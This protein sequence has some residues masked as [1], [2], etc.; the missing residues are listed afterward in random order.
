MIARALSTEPKLVL[1]D[2]PTGSL[3]TQPRRARCWSCCASSAASARLAV[4]LVTHDPQAAAFADRVHTL[5][6]GQLVGVRARPAVGRGRRA[7]DEVRLSSILLLYRARLRARVVLVQELFAVARHRRGRGA[8][9][10]LAGRQHEPQR[11][12]GAS[13]RGGI[14]GDMRLPA[15]GARPGRLRRDGCW[16]R[17]SASPGVQRGG[18]GARGARQRDRP[19]AASS[20]WI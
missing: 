7:A 8:A 1:A 17:C 10:R 18:A 14:V 20:R 4:L 13:S 9:V 6:D 16:A 19:A 11:L 12:G 2:E 5:R 15:R 3:D